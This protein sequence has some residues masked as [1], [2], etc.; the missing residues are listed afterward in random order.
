MAT[1]QAPPPRPP[2][3]TGPTPA[4]PFGGAP[5]DIFDILERA[6]LA[7]QEKANRAAVAALAI[8]PV[9]PGAT[10]PSDIVADPAP[11][12]GAEPIVGPAVKPIVLGADTLPAA[13][14]KRGWWKR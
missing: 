6:E 2:A 10:A 5:F 8:P 4:D 3:Y 14:P 7:E 12:A 1:P 11:P 13:A 9:P